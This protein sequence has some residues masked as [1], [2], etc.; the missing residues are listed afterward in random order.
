MLQLERPQWRVSLE[1][2]READGSGGVDARTS[3]GEGVEALVG[4]EGTRE[5]DDTSLRAES[6]RAREHKPGVSSGG[7]E[8][9]GEGEV[10]VC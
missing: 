7:G 4:S 8:G 2:V 3:E 9:E 1:S 10:E 6:T 5:G